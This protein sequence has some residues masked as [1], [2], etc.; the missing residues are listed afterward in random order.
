MIFRPAL[1]MTVFAVP[2]L[3]IL[4]ALGTWQVKRLQWKDELISEFTARAMGEAITPPAADAASG[5]RFQRLNLAG[6]WM[7]DAEV[8]LIGRTFEGTAGYHVITPFRLDDGRI[9]L[10]NRGWVSQ[11]YRTPQKRPGTLHAGPQEFQAIL[12]LPARKG[13]FVPGNNPGQNDWFTL[14]I[15]DIRAHHDLGD[16]VIDGY[17]A[18]A[19]RADGPYVLPIGA[20]VEITIPNDHLNYA[21]TWYGI[22]LGL[23]GVYFAWHH[24]SGRL[25]FRR[26]SGE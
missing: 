24:Q 6:E 18:D 9:L 23:I 21:I 13:Y 26:G 20:A 10:V 25:Q 7:H 8:Q 22:A 17:S 11:D 1:W 4:L 3:V 15:G 19:L 16:A 5:L 14:D 2:S 12:R